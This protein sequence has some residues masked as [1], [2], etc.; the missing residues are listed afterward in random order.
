MLKFEDKVVIITGASAGIGKDAVKSF[1]GEGAKVVMIGR[2]EGKLQ[3]AA[4][5]L[6]L[7]EGKPKVPH[8]EGRT[9]NSN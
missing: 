2:R 3:E 4:K 5:E 6:G 7:Q 1:A 8:E 9:T